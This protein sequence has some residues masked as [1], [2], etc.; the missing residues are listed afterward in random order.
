MR[1]GGPPRPIIGGGIPGGGIPGGG[2]LNG[3]WPGA[4]CVCVR[5]CMHVYESR[6][7]NTK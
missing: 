5:A 2:R 4:V 3:E 1:G 7:T 6:R